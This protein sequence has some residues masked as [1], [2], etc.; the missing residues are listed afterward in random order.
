MKVTLDIPDEIAQDPNFSRAEWLRE[1]AIA[2]F[3][4]ERVTLGIASQI[5]GMHP[6][7][8]QKCL[9]SRGGYVHY[10]VEEFEADMQNLQNRGWL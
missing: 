6:I 1:I 9:G 2:L 4:Q 10:D 5:A 7:E 3:E 8:F